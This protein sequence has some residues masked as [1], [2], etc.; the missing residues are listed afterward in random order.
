MKLI[1]TFAAKLYGDV[2]TLFADT[3]H[4]R[5]VIQS[6]TQ[7]YCSYIIP[8]DMHNKP[9]VTQH[10]RQQVIMYIAV[11]VTEETSSQYNIIIVIIYCEMSESTQWHCDD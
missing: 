5:K 8:A 10:R 4:C 6:G 2:P 9:T 7:R 3:N 1:T 11:I